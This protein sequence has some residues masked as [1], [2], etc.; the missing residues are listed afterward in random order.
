[1]EY[2]GETLGGIPSVVVS[3]PGPGS[4]GM[5]DM[6]GPG[7]VGFDADQ[8]SSIGSYADSFMLP[9]GNVM[10]ATGF[11]PPK[12]KEEKKQEKARQPFRDW[13]KARRRNETPLRDRWQNPEER[14]KILRRGGTGLLSLL[15]PQFRMAQSLYK[16]GKGMKENPQ[17]IL[18]ALG[19]MFMQQKLG[20]N[21]DLFRAGMGLAKG[22]PAG[23]VMSNL[24]VGRGLRAG[25]GQLAPS[26]F[27]K[28]YAEQGMRGVYATSQL[29]NALMPMAQKGI[30][31][32]LGGGG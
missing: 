28:A 26:L 11:T 4:F 27:R 10:S 13:V 20:P 19:N 22:A 1:M 18:G 8:F 30:T 15:F 16:F 3:A 29:L 2:Q 5:P 25:I 12:K 31:G 21:A 32:K 7:G 6:F 23:D 17:G 14:R 24:L 9:S